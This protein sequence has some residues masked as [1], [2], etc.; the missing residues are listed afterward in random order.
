[1]HVNSFLINRSRHVTVSDHC[2]ARVSVSNGTRQ[3]CVLSPF[4]YTVYT[5]SY[6][7]VYYS[8]SHCFKYADDTAL[9]RLLSNDEIDYRVTYITLCHGVWVTAVS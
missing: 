4:V 5:N 8:I 9:V 6:R 7:R 1:M 3:G 2:S